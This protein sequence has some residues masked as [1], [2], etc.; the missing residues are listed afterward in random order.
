MTT[1]RRH[2]WPDFPDGVLPKLHRFLT[3]MPDRFGL[4]YHGADEL[5]G[6]AHGVIPM[7]AAADLFHPETRV[8]E[9]YLD[10]RDRLTKVVL[11]A[12]HLSDRLDFTYVVSAEGLL[13]TA[14]ANPKAA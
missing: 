9:V 1:L 2:R 4:T 7:P 10:E 6:D 13:V 5:L 12:P 8:A 14:W 11:L 3:R